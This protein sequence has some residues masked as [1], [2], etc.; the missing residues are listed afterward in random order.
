M[1]NISLTRCL[2]PINNYIYNGGLG[3]SREKE[4]VYVKGKLN[5]LP[6]NHITYSEYSGALIKY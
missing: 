2:Y 6:L 4:Q 1:K 3:K 5:S